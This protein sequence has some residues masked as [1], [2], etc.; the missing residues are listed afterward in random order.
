LCENFISLLLYGYTQIYPDIPRYP[1][2]IRVPALATSIQIGTHPAYPSDTSLGTRCPKLLLL[3]LKP[4][5][6]FARPLATNVPIQQ[7]KKKQNIICPARG[8]WNRKVP[9]NSTRCGRAVFDIICGHSVQ[10]STD[11]RHTASLLG[12]T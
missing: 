11:G 12:A 6:K 1:P 5:R 4:S 8:N 3:Y 9:G 2:R 7:I 10:L